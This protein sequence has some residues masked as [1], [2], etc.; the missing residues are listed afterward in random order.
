MAIPNNGFEDADSRK[1]NYQG[2]NFTKWDKTGH[3][4]MEGTAK[5]WEDLRIEP[6]ARTTGANAPTFEQWFDD[7]A[8]GDTGSS[9]GVYLYSFADGASEMEIFFSAQMPHAW[10][11]G[12]ISIHAHWVPYAAATDKKVIWGLEYNFKRIG[13]VFGGNA[14]IVY[15]T[16]LFPADAD[17]V[18]GKHYIS[19]FADITPGATQNGISAILIGRLFRKSND[20]AD[21][22]TNKAG[23]LYIDIHYQLNSLGST[24]EYT[25]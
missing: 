16:A 1:V 3:Q 19:E 18:A 15:D 2:A 13:E 14:A 6:Q 12:A 17:Y 10:D 11:G 23:L 20:A 4:T 8:I 22:Y 24:D 7:T 25:K 5:P 9:R 21:N